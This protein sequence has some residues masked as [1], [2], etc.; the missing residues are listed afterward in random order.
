MYDAGCSGQK[1]QKFLSDLLGKYLL[2]LVMN[3]SLVRNS[4]I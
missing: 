2:L 3:K 4:S 1:K